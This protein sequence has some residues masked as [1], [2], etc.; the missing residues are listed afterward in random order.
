M[1][2]EIIAYKNSFS[3]LSSA[4]TCSSLVS[5]QVSSSSNS[6]LATFFPSFF[7][8]NKSDTIAA[9]FSNENANKNKINDDSPSDLLAALNRK[10][11]HD[12]K[13]NNTTITTTSASSLSSSSSCIVQSL[14]K[15]ICKID[16]VS[17]DITSKST[18]AI[19]NSFK[20][21]TLPRELSLKLSESLCSSAS[22]SNELI[23]SFEF[24]SRFQR[25]F[26]KI[27]LIILD[28]RVLNDYN[29][30]RIKNSIHINC[31]DKI[32]KKRI[33]SG[34]IKILDL[35]YS[36]ICKKQQQKTT[37]KKSDLN[38][39]NDNSNVICDNKGVGDDDDTSN[40]CFVNNCSSFD[41][42]VNSL[43]NNEESLILI[44]DEAA[45]AYASSGASSDSS[46]SSTSCTASNYACSYSDDSNPLKI[47]QKNIKNTG[48]EKDCRILIGD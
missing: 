25:G 22:S 18:A 15:K 12:T 20:F 44:Y 34:K 27:P 31:Q 7:L 6:G 30:K 26:G 32:S 17:T 29:S 11:E 24:L 38:N 19:P 9:E 3:N 45:A 13:N 28:C 46:T 39:N 14:V 33:S 10:S 42:F 4:S 23:D 36:E 2:F 40:S 1:A 48:F 8:T 35:V 5:T 21:L 41:T 16:S 37:L 47:V 43:N